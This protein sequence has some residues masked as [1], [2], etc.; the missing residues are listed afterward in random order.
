MS[1]DAE[2]TISTPAVQVAPSESRVTGVWKVAGLPLESS[3]PLPATA[4]PGSGAASK[5][6]RR[7]EALIIP[8][9]FTATVWGM[10]GFSPIRSPAGKFTVSVPR[11]DDRDFRAAEDTRRI[12]EEAPAKLK[13][14]GIETD[15]L[16]TA[17]IDV[18]FSLSPRPQGSCSCWTT[19]L[20]G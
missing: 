11:G 17:P 8:K 9:D 12:L 7:R 13:A 10:A 3:A 5:D 6:E 15:S 18:D 20:P 19:S 2:L 14:I 4:P 1:S 16:R